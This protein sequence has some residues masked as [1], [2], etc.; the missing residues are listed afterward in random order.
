MADVRAKTPTEAG[1]IAVPGIGE[2]R[3]DMEF[4]RAS[5]TTALESLI[6]SMMRDV[7]EKNPARNKNALYERIER[8]R[9]E[10]RDIVNRIKMFNYDF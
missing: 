9:F 1:E 6:S 3:E 8:S 4:I 2:I 5:M 10:C 7:D